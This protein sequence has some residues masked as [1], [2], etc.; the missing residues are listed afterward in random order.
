MKNAKLLELTDAGMEDGQHVYLEIRSGW[1]STLEPMI[2]EE[3]VIRPGKH[4]LDYMKFKA[5][6]GDNVRR[7]RVMFYGML[8]RCWNAQPTM[9]QRLAARWDV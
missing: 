7:L 4:D 3:F 1:T 2:L 9:T 5:P 8:W 6:K